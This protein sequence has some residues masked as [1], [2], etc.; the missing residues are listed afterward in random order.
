M[1]QSEQV[2]KTHNKLSGKKKT[3][4]SPS[5]GPM[6]KGS[7]TKVFIVQKYIVFVHIVQFWI[8][9]SVSCAISFCWNHDSVSYFAAGFAIVFDVDFIFF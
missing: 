9:P 4:P 1:R 6:K 2:V 7:I 3:H 8:D 5:I